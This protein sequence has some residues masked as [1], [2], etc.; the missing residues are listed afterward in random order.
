MELKLAQLIEAGPG[1]AILGQR[2]SVQ[3]DDFHG[4]LVSWDGHIESAVAI[5]GPQGA[6]A[7]SL[8][9][10]ASIQSIAEPS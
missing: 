2:P 4:S 9:L 6:V 3:N 1:C 7:K 8:P 5:I 10:L